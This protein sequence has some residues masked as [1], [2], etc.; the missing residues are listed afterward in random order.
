[1]GLSMSQA[2]R[3]ATASMWVQGGSE[4]ESSNQVCYS[5][6]VGPGCE[7][8]NQVCYSLNVGL[9]MSM[10]NQVCYSPNVACR[11]GLR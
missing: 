9:S 2:T 10:S 8:S 7:S 1:M 4:Y 5:L 11:G 6:N 3:S